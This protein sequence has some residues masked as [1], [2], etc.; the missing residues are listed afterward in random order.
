MSINRMTVYLGD[1]DR[2]YQ[3]RYNYIP[4]LPAKISGPPEHCYPGETAEVSIIE[5]K[6]VP[7]QEGVLGGWREVVA[8]C[9]RI[10]DYIYEHHE[11]TYEA[12]RGTN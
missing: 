3:V 7:L 10:V 2:E 11:D 1:G 9:D 12:E 5:C 4:S 6:P 8:E